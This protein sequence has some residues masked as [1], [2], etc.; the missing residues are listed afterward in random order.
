MTHEPR[1][2]LTGRL[3]GFVVS[4]AL[5]V[6]ARLRIPDLLAAGP[7]PLAELADAAG[8]DP[9][10]LYRLLRMLAGQDVFVEQAG[11]TF[12]NSAASELLRDVPDSLRAFA[13]EAGEV[14]Y[15]TLGEILW[16][17]QTGRP[18]FETVFGAV[19]EE[20]LV[21]NPEASSRFDRL[22]TARQLEL[23]DYLADR[24][25]RGHETVVDVGGGDGALLH[26]LLARRAGIRGIVFDLPGRV[27]R[28]RER[29]AA[30]GLTDRC[31]TVSGSYV[32]GV[33]AG[34]DVYVLSYVLHN[35]ADGNAVEI[36]RAVRRAM[37]DHGHVLV[38]EEVVA[39]PNQPDGKVG[40]LL[41]FAVGGRERTEQ[42]WRALLA[43]GGLQLA[44]VRPGPNAS[45]LEA[46]T[47]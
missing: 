27:A 21:R 41:V 42:E 28:A 1:S 30:A 33:P 5:Y 23:V 8:A 2:E 25:W 36:L 14:S 38:V 24:E 37:P 9:D 31:Q 47:C 39:P 32:Q 12:A 15:P 3:L 29:I 20:H 6:A 7:R 35:W 43:D 26:G 10:A 19:W 46:W 40:D 4:Q 44:D 34:G 17:V 45:I 16:M 13:L 22:L 11:G 18:A